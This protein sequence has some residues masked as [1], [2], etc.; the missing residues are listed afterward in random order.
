MAHSPESFEFVDGDRFDLRIA[1]VTKRLGRETVRMLAYNG[2][3]PGP[4]LRV[5]QGSELI[6]N[7]TNDGDL[8]ATVHWHGLRL[9]NRS[10]GTTATQR[11][12]PVGGTF[13]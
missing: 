7:V 13:T 11:P 6:V 1:P 12:I 2:S 5:K 8:E 3:I 10:D 4:I 9:D